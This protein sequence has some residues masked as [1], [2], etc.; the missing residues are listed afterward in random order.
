MS[1]ITDA[2]NRVKDAWGTM[3]G[4]Q[5]IASI[6]IALLIVA[7][8]VGG[9]AIL[10]PTKKAKKAERT[11]KVELK[12]LSVDSA[13]Y[14]YVAEGQKMH[15]PV[16]KKGEDI[17]TFLPE[18]FF[19]IVGVLGSPRDS[20]S[21][22]NFE[23][24]DIWLVLKSHSSSAKM[25]IFRLRTQPFILKP[26]PKGIFELEVPPVF[27]REKG[28]VDEKNIRRLAELFMAGDFLDESKPITQPTGLFLYVELRPCD[29]LAKI[30]E[31]PGELKVNCSQP[32]DRLYA[33]TFNKVA[34]EEKDRLVIGLHEFKIFRWPHMA[35][36]D[37][38][39]CHYQVRIVTKE[40]IKRPR[41]EKLLPGR[42]E[43]LA[44][45]GLV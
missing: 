31:L 25:F 35:R 17:E 18:D 33:E 44:G 40:D 26:K 39:S 20:K 9:I 42:R 24:G 6:G 30:K 22:T 37:I 4:L 19:E 28:G 16:R 34:K 12:D 13:G 38:D 21:L 27:S 14:I 23:K 7:I 29:G 43:P 1:Y 3:S 36:G 41:K 32:E 11:E 15:F 45:S 5:K 8:F 2:V 10:A